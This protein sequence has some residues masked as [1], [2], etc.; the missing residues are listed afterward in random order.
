[1]KAATKWW[2]RRRRRRRK[3]TD[4]RW[5]NVSEGDLYNYVPVP[6]LLVT[7]LLQAVLWRIYTDGS[8]ALGVTENCRNNGCSR[9]SDGTET[10]QSNEHLPIVVSVLVDTTAHKE[11]TFTY[12][13]P[14]Q[15][16]KRLAWGLYGTTRRVVPVHNNELTSSKCLRCGRNGASYFQT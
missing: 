1:M 11:H 8:G 7:L 16:L 5:P 13:L 3:K 2:K 10:R 9:P 12:W 6:F 15:L 4:F 14:P